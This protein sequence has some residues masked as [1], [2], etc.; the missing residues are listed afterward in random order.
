MA[1]WQESETDLSDEVKVADRDFKYRTV[2]NVG[3]ISPGRC[4][5]YPPYIPASA[6]VYQVFLT[7]VW[8]QVDF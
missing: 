7:G 2:V 5:D 4:H 1:C 8:R 3:V 6:L